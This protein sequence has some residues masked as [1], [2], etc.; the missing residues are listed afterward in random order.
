MHEFSSAFLPQYTVRHR[1]ISLCDMLRS[2]C[3]TSPVL[4]CDLL[5]FMHATREFGLLVGPWTGK[6]LPK[7]G[8]STVSLGASFE[9]MVKTPPPNSCPPK[10]PR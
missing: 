7:I 3:A 2:R 5:R 10:N 9:N 1:P 6:A 4:L 8:F